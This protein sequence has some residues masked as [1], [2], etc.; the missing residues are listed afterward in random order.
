MHIETVSPYALQDALVCLAE[1]LF[2]V[3]L[4]SAVLLCF[5]EC[6]LMSF[7]LSRP[8]EPYVHLLQA[9]CMKYFVS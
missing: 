3:P 9:G 1:D 6:V 4:F 2:E 8:Q 5:A 7:A